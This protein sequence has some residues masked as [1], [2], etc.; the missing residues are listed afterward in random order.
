MGRCRPS[1]VS[2]IKRRESRLCPSRTFCPRARPKEV[3]DHGRPQG[4][5]QQFET[6]RNCRLT[7]APR[8]SL[9]PQIQAKTRHAYGNAKSTS[10]TVRAPDPALPSTLRK[11]RRRSQQHPCD[12]TFASLTGQQTSISPT[13]PRSSETSREHSGSPEALHNSRP[14]KVVHGPQSRGPA[15][16]CAGNVSNRYKGLECGAVSSLRRNLE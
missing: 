10:A 16:A 5:G 3:V 7:D 1:R 6:L 8:F 12:A 15:L 4:I 13:R 9:N 14:T 11:H 2:T